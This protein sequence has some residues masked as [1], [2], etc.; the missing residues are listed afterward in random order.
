MEKREFLR[1]LSRALSPLTREERARM[2][3]YYAE[4]IDDRVEQ[5]E[6]E[7]AVIAG[8]GDIRQLADGLVADAASRGEL[9][10]GPKPLP[11][12]L[13]VLG[14]PIWLVLLVCLAV[15]ILCIYVVAWVVVVTL[16]F[17][18]FSLELAG[19]F[20]IFRLFLFLGENPASAFFVFGAG[21]VCAGLGLLLAFPVIQLAKWL[22]KA[23]ARLAS[24]LWHGATDRFRRTV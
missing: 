8:L 9:R 24:R 11:T 20:G 4:M 10:Q 21:T 13:I 16:L 22:A 6:N 15:V 23:A 3:E 12:V 14:S 17:T 19:V 18:V 2:L 1:R 5:G 7:A